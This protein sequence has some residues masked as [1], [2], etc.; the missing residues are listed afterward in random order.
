MPVQPSHDFLHRAIGATNSAKRFHAITVSGM[1]SSLKDSFSCGTIWHIIC[2]SC[3][4]HLNN[5]REGI[6][7]M[8]KRII[9]S[10]I[11]TLWRSG[12]MALGLIV[13]GILMSCA[14][15]IGNAPLHLS[16]KMP[17][18]VAVVFSDEFNQAGGD[19]Y[20][21]IEALHIELFDR[22]G[23]VYQNTVEEFEIPAKEEYDRIIKFTL[24]EVTRDEHNRR[25]ANVTDPALPS[26][27]IPLRFR[28]SVTM[29]SYGGEDAELIQTKVVK[30]I[31][32]SSSQEG[33]SIREGAAVASSSGRG[34]YDKAVAEAFED[35][36]NEVTKLLIQGFAEPKR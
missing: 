22:V 11:N 16:E 23:G 28:I 30:G 33:V 12:V 27:Y 14:G 15:S 1:L 2:N 21:I 24:N 32:E 29:A 17:Y 8:L 34:S 20:S 31:G 9:W 13:L 26:R 36:C 19:N 5:D 10:E 6:S 4:Y 7:K 3:Y 35:L 18:T 25:L